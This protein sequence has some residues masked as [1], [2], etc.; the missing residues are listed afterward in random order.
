MEIGTS[1]NAHCITIGSSLDYCHIPGR[2]HHEQL[3]PDTLSV[4]QGIHNEAVCQDFANSGS[5]TG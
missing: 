4:A 1:V 5:T 3:P 2:A